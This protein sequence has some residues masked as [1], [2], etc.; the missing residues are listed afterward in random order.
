[1]AFR[2]FGRLIIDQYEKRPMMMNSI[3]GGGVY[4][5]AEI[6]AE[7]NNP[8]TKLDAKRISPIAALGALEVG[9]LM[10]VW[11]NILD[12][13]IG[14][15]VASSVVLAKCAADQLFFA[16]QGDGLFLAMCAGLDSKDL[17]HA[18]REVKLNFV[19]TWLNDCAV[20]P[21]VNFIGFWQ[22]P[23]KLVPTY[24]ASMQLLWQLYLSMAQQKAPPRVEDTAPAQ[25]TAPIK[26]R[27]SQDVKLLPKDDTRLDQIFSEF[28]T[29]GSESIDAGELRSALERCP[30][31]IL[32]LNRTK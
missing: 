26:H 6:I 2:R 12:R 15:S 10:T 25:N 18:I 29:D 13:Y 27:S 23:T 30:N 20:W 3:V 19:T 14:T 16:T 5:C 7:L 32:R 17:P 4:G 31:C 21:L 9:G 8:G 24:M 22:V 11:Y 28:D 1:M